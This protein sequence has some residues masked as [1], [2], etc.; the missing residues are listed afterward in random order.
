MYVTICGRFCRDEG[1]RSGLRQP[2]E[3]KIPRKT[4]VQIAGMIFQTHFRKKAAASILQ[5]PKSNSLF[6]QLFYLCTL[7]YALS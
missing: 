1:R 2:N 6:Y 3:G 5:Q 7:S 4:G